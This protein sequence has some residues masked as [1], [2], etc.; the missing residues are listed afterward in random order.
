MVFYPSGIYNNDPLV[1]QKLL[2]GVWMKKWEYCFV[3]SGQTASQSGVFVVLPDGTTRLASRYDESLVQPLMV[4]NHYGL[5]G[6]EVVGMETHSFPDG[7]W[8]TW[9]LK[10]TP[11]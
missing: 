2:G 11:A 3:R 1:Y 8:T 7:Y 9:T 10:R 5:Q 6:W 4:L